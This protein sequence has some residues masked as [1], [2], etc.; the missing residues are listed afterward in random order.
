V[1]VE[2]RKE[3]V[4]TVKRDERLVTRDNGKE[5][6]LIWISEET[7]KLVWVDRKI[8]DEIRKGKKENILELHYV[9]DNGN[10]HVVPEISLDSALYLVNAMPGDKR[11]IITTP[12]GE[13]VIEELGAFRSLK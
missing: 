1:K 11:R 6:W 9:D 10:C 7:V 3:A 5:M 4:R 2:K 13:K 12:E 8:I